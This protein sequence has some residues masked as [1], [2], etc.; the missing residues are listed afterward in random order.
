MEENNVVALNRAELI[1]R[2]RE[3]CMEGANDS[4][5]YVGK[6]NRARSNIDRSEVSQR[7]LK[8]K[9]FVIRLVIAGM[10]LLSVILLDQFQIK[11]Q[12]FSSK[13]IIS[14]IHSNK[15]YEGTKDLVDT[16]ILR[17]K[18]MNQKNQD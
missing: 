1:K 17:D 7:G 6:G 16:Y 10:L 15:L 4:S 13:Q 2:A 14:M 5:S 11:Y 12:N 3:S 9:F 18:D 8:V